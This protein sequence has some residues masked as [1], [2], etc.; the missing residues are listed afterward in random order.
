LISIDGKDY[1][2]EQISGF[3]LKKLKEDA[4]KFL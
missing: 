4:E 2:P 3:V 1:K